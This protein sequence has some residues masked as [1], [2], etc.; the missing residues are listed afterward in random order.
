MQNH[1]VGTAFL[2]LR[3]RMEERVGERRRFRNPLSSIL[4]PLVPHGERK[5][6]RWF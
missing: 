4:S 2:S 5:G 1:A 6:S 3:Q